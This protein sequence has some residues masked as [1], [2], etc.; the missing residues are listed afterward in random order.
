MAP[1]A[2]GLQIVSGIDLEQQRFDRS[3]MRIVAVGAVFR[4]VVDRF[5]RLDLGGD[6]FVA[7]NAQVRWIFDGKL[8][9]VFRRRVALLTFSS[10]CEIRP[11]IARMVSDIGVTFAIR[12]RRGRVDRLGWLSRAHPDLRHH[13]QQK[14]DRENDKARGTRPSPVHYSTPLE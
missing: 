5:R 4:R 11:V 14:C 2:E 6:V 10:I 9:Q 1:E 13:R 3:T 12:T 7:A 8:V